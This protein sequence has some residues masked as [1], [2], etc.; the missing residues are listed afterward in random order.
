MRRYEENNR[1]LNSFYAPD[2]HEE[3]REEMRQEIDNLKKELSSK[4]SREDDEEKRQLALME[5]SYQMAAKYL[6]TTSA[7][8]PS[9]GNAFTDGKGGTATTTDTGTA[10]GQDAHANTPVMEDRK[11]VV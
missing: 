5:Q 11:S 8:P 3:E 7:T 10:K 9:L 1:L 6:P 4:D 2:P